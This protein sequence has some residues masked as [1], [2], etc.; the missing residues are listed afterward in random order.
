[1]GEVEDRQSVAGARRMR[2]ME[3][4]GKKTGRGRLLSHLVTFSCI[5]VTPQS[6]LEKYERPFFFFFFAIVFHTT[7]LWE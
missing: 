1:M 3:T 5:L 4:S 2:R 6:S 7:E